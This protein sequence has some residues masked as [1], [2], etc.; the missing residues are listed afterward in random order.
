M[1]LAV[2]SQSVS[3]GSPSAGTRGAKASRDTEKGVRVSTSCAGACKL[4]VCLRVLKVFK[5][6]HHHALDGRELLLEHV[7]E[8]LKHCRVRLWGHVLDQPCHRVFLFGRVKRPQT[9]TATKRNTKQSE[10]EAA[11]MILA[12]HGPRPI[13]AALLLDGGVPP[14]LLARF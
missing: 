9:L 6:R 3:M 10:V 5:V 2:G 14:G 7:V 11:A 13:F 12:V 4:F 1:L 8:P